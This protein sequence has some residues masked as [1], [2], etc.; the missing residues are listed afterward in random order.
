MGIIKANKIGDG[1]HSAVDSALYKVILSL[2]P[3]TICGLQAL[4]GVISEYS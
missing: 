1:N 3:N 4:P 2:I